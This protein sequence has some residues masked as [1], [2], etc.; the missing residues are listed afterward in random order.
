MLVFILVILFLLIA[1]INFVF[2]VQSNS[3]RAKP[4]ALCVK[5]KTRSDSRANFQD[6][7]FGFSKT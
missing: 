4:L 2:G 5:V 3:D 1:F 7:I 6:C